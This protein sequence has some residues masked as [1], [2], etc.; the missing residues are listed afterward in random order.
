MLTDPKNKTE[1]ID[2]LRQEKD[3]KVIKVIKGKASDL[4][5]SISV[6][7]G[8]TVAVIVIESHCLST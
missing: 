8:K 4:S 7:G 3:F 5:K 1:L 6:L 2:C